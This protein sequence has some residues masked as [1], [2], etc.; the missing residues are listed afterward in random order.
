M[1]EV[2]SELDA[3][4]KEIG[5]TSYADTI[6]GSVE[7]NADRLSNLESA[8]RR[9]IALMRQAVKEEIDGA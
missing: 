6:R 8:M 2:I 9:V 4:E 1:E 3:I 5:R 7:D